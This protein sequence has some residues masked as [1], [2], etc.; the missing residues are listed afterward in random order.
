MGIADVWNNYQAAQK[1][2]IQ[3]AYARNSISWPS[4]NAA[5]PGGMGDVGG[6]SYVL[7]GQPDKAP[8]LPSIADAE[9][10][11][12]NI[13][14]GYS[15]IPAT[16]KPVVTTD[17][18]YV[19]RWTEGGG[20]PAQ[21]VS[22]ST[23]PVG[24]PTELERRTQ[25][26]INQVSTAPTGQATPVATTP[27]TTTATIP[28][29]KYMYQWVEANPGDGNLPI[30]RASNT[31][32]PAGTK[33]VTRVPISSNESA[34]PTET[35]SETEK[36]LSFIDHLQRN[37]TKQFGFDP[38]MEDP[39][40]RAYREVND[41]YT[42]SNMNMPGYHQQMTDDYNRKV[43]E[44]TNA[45]QNAMGMLKFGLEQFAIQNPVLTISNIG[46]Q[47]SIA[48]QRGKAGYSIIGPQGVTAL[49]QGGGAVV[50]GPGGQNVIQLT[51]HPVTGVEGGFVYD[52][53]KLIA[54]PGGK[55]SGAGAT[56]TALHG[57]LIP[58]L[59]GAR[60]MALK[61]GVSPKILQEA[62]QR[63]DMSSSTNYELNA[64]QKLNLYGSMLKLPADKQKFQS[65]LNKIV[66]ITS[67]RR[68][69]ASPSGSQFAGSQGQWG[70][71]SKLGVPVFQSAE[72]K[73]FD[74]SGKQLDPNTI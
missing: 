59:N 41:L 71:S 22:G 55:S 13:A 10:G 68:G 36:Q 47:G 43:K 57:A 62:E 11:L 51:P 50:S 42:R 48:S 46:A 9:R 16:P 44:Y 45:K 7:P 23:V 28:V 30:Q 66:E 26:I 6:V 63:I 17:N 12:T 19:R 69:L 72:G 8:V 54:T 34:M 67:P 74:Q 52:K 37:I 14:S 4:F 38:F 18:S 40:T 39:E 31:P 56:P 27:T 3:D 73:Y 25:E 33:G 70:Q 2:E 64:Q 29:Q 60:D 24:T 5:D 15:G 32:P 65:I 21:R 61:A 35:K 20:V 1:K 58:L 53:G 49:A